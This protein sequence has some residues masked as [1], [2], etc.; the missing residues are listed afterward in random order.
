MSTTAVMYPIVS[1]LIKAEEIL[2]RNR[3]W[4][5]EEGNKLQERFLAEFFGPCRSERFSTEEMETIVAWEAEKINQFLAE[6]NIDVRLKEFGP[7]SFGLASIQNMEVKWRTEGVATQLQDSTGKSFP[8]V[9]LVDDELQF[10]R[11]DHHAHPICRV[12]TTSGYD[13]F[14]TKFD[15]S[16]E[17]FD[18]IAMAE[19]LTLSRSP[20]YGEF[21]GLTFPM[22]DLNQEVDVS[23]LL[24]MYTFREL[25]GRAF[26]AQ[27]LQQ[28]ILKLDRLG[29]KV[30]SAF[31][32]E[33]ALESKHIE[34]PQML[35]DSSFMC[36]FVR[37]HMRKPLFVGHITQDDWDQ[38]A[39]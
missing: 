18:L 37:Q 31:T 33:T 6:R 26:I 39:A 24:N 1:A 16:L 32:A 7:N 4:R 23:W 27:A 38:P 14:M 13:V 25:G 35:I 30:R 11:S 22:V 36:W 28:T 21:G 5:F 20:T 15:Q 29:A 10:Y 8:A 9:N 12:P 3:L 19:E 34:L 17:H 2:G